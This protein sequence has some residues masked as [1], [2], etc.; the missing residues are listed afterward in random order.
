M[1]RLNRWSPKFFRKKSLIQKTKNQNNVI[2]EIIVHETDTK[3]F[4]EDDFSYSSYSD[5]FSMLSREI[6]YMI[7]HF[8]SISEMGRVMSVSKSWH[9]LCEQLISDQRFRTCN[10]QGRKAKLSR[11]PPPPLEVAKEDQIEDTIFP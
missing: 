4:G 6:I 10:P 3:I 11:L 8:L 2:P 7:F 1:N 9:Q 5:S